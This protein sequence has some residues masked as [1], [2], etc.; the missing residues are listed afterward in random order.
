MREG[1][2]LYPLPPL[3][4]KRN[5]P[6]IYFPCSNSWLFL[7]V[8]VEP[9]DRFLLGP[10]PRLVVDAVMLD[11]GDIHQFLDAGGAFMGEDRVVLVVEELLV[12]GDDEQLRAV[13]AAAN[14]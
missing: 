1:G 14:I 9:R 10:L 2:D 6:G 3:I 7:Q 12:L 8:L 11:S 13:P 4:V 5:A